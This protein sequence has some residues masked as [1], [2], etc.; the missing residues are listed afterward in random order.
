MYRACV[1]LLVVLTGCSGVGFDSDSPT[2]RS[3][4]PVTPVPVPAA[5]PATLRTSG[6]DDDGVSD[7]AALATAHGQWLAN[8]S[9]TLT[10][11]QTVRYENGTVR[12]QYT[13]HL[14]LTE[15]RTYHAAVRTG[16][17]DGPKVLGEPPAY[18][19][20]WS[21]RETYVRAFGEPDPRYN[22]F[23]PTASGVGTWYF[24]AMT[25]S[26]TFRMT[27]GVMIQSSFSEVPTR[28]ETRRIEA[29]VPRYRLTSPEPTT[30]SLPFPDAVPARNVSLT[31]EVDGTGLV[32]QL[33]LDYRGRIDEEPV[34]VT[35]RISYTNVGSTDA[36][37]PEWFDEATDST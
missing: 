28:I 25:G 14:R 17:V 23:S 5:D 20:F 4:E 15:D 9:Y 32:R 26:F 3:V 1:I 10:S 30:A 33:R 21:D 36:D 8:R 35:R 24:W 6:I 29:G 12:S 27:P 34:V 7:P 13:V 2:D 16:G 19:E 18:A 37:R 11:N 31:A 22:E